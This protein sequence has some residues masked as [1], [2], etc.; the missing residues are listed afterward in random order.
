MH[1]LYR[2]FVAPALEIHLRK[3]K[4]FSLVNILENCGLIMQ[5]INA[6]N[7]ILDIENPLDPD[8]TNTQVILI[9][10]YYLYKCRCLGD[11]PS[12]NGGIIYLKYYIKIEKTTIK[13]QKEYICRKWLPFET[14]LGDWNFSKVL[15]HV[16]FINQMSL[17]R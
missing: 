8:N 17:S 16:G 7:I 10:R 11:N 5:Y 2:N 15:Q 6:P 12:I 9:V 4:L 13:T 14:V 1:L 3:A